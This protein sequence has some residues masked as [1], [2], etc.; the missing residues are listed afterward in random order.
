MAAAVASVDV[1]IK[2]TKVGD[3]ITDRVLNDRLV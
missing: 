3:G 1:F 2:N